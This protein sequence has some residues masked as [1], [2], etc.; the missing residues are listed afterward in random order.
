[1]G[2]SNVYLTGIACPISVYDENG[3][4]QLRYHGPY[5]RMQVPNIA[6]SLSANVKPVKIE[7]K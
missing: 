1:M 7:Y 2:T 5:Y 4:N 3:S 6:A